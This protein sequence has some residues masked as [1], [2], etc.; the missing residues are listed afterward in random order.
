M[1]K[2][3][4]VT[5]TDYY[6]LGNRLQA[7]AVYSILQKYGDVYNIIPYYIK[8]SENIKIKFKEIIKFFLSMFFPKFKR[9]K[10]RKN[11]FLKFSM[12][13]KNEVI[14]KSKREYDSLNNKYDFF[15]I[16]SDQIW[17]PNFYSTEQMLAVNMLYFADNTKKIAISPSI[18]VSNIDEK[19][20]V[21][22]NKYLQSFKCL[23]CREE[24]GAELIKNITGKECVTLLDP[25]LMLSLQDWSKIE[26]KPSFHNIDQKY[27]L[28]YFLSGYSDKTK[29]TIK[30]IAEKN[31]LQIVDI[32]DDKSKYFTC[33]P[34]EFIYLVHNASIIL[35]D[36]FHACVF[37]IIFEK[38]FRVFERE[39][40]GANMNSRIIN[41]IDKLGLKK[42]VYID[43]N[44]NFNFENLFETN[45]DYSKL[46]NEQ[47]K[48]KKYLD[49]AFEE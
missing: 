39:N 43:S 45:Y 35:T 26:K 32:Y 48:F 9:K 3:G 37:S 41:L 30:I 2:I 29:N 12:Y 18:G 17:N 38:S 27:I 36:S 10:E 34:S 47:D 1:K 49:K 16:G 19:Y 6:N 42:D 15:T 14:L 13:I 20:K 24:Q 33:G 4:M 46:K 21:I 8:P 44:S 40:G 11:N 23:S 31:K 5:K 25:T 7:Y 22:F 28:L